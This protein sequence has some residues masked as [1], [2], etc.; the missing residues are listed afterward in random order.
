MTDTFAAES[1]SETSQRRRTAEVNEFDAFLQLLQDET[2]RD[3]TDRLLVVL[4]KALRDCVDGFHVCCGLRGIPDAIGFCMEILEAGVTDALVPLCELIEKC[5]LP[6]RIAKLQDE[7]RLKSSL[8]SM[9]NAV[10][11]TLSVKEELVKCTAAS[12][13]EQIM[14]RV[15]RDC[16]DDLAVGLTMTHAGSTT[17]SVCS[18]ARAGRS[19]V[20]SPGSECG[21]EEKSDRQHALQLAVMGSFVLSALCAE[22]RRESLPLNVEMAVLRALREASTFCF[23]CEVLCQEGCLRRLFALLEGRDLQDPAAFLLVEVIWNVLEL[24]PLAREQLQEDG[25]RVIVTFHTLVRAALVDGYR[26]RDKEFRNDCLS[27]C[28]LLAGDTRTHQYFYESGFTETLFLAGF[29]LELNLDNEVLQRITG[30]M[31]IQDFELKR[32]AWNLLY[33]LSFHPANAQL[34]LL[35]GAL[36]ALLCYMDMSCPNPVVRRWPTLQLMDLQAQALHVV[37]Q[38]ALQGPEKFAEVDGAATLLRFLHDGMDVALRN[39]T[40]RVVVH[41][42]N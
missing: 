4:R 37:C 1:L 42:A 3:Q 10:A 5:T 8:V 40:L 2:T 7:L 21:G 25:L 39:T 28:T 26:V 17:S 27:V 41:L 6:F 30:S 29:G 13:V 22:L 33:H 12:A 14:A 16:T 18:G 11:S 24:F 23:G 36:E 31:A 9:L 38:L 20:S 32:L 15:R 35:R 19:L 34:L